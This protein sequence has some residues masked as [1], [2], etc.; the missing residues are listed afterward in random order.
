MWGDEIRAAKFAAQAV[1]D[2][3]GSVEAGGDLETIRPSVDLARVAI[4][5]LPIEDPQRERYVASVLRDLDALKDL[6]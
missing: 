1:K 2:A 4:A 6:A 5:A 3:L